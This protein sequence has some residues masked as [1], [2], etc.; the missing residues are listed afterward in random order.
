[1]NPFG[2]VDLGNDEEEEEEMDEFQ[3]VSD[4]T[5]KETHPVQSLDNITSQD[6]KELANNEFAAQIGT[7]SMVEV[8]PGKY[9]HKARVL[10]EYMQYL[11]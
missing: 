11:R 3:Q 4:H 6:L 8:S 10:W 7:K 9:V 5:W 1:M 2:G